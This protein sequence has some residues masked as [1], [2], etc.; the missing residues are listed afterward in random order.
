MASFEP[1]RPVD[2]PLA[3][4]G[5]EGRHLEAFLH[6]LVDG[7]ERGSIRAVGH[8]LAD[9]DLLRHS[10]I[11]GSEAGN[12][13]LS[14]RSWLAEARAFECANGRGSMRNLTHPWFKANMPAIESY[15]RWADPG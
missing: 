1:S 12:A 8:A 14:A 11:P 9:E 15:R 2:E 13:V 7:M 3:C 5:A 4:I 10:R 6:I